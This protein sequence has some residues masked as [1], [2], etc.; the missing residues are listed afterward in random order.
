MVPMHVSMNILIP[1]EINIV[2]K[3]SEHTECF[4]DIMYFFRY[5]I[6]L[7]IQTSQILIA[8]Q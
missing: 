6:F 4:W 8:A 1:K 5:V 3:T 2:P 7:R